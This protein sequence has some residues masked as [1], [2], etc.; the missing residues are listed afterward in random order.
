M[1]MP[2]FWQ[3][4][5]FQRASASLR[6]NA[7]LYL[8]QVSSVLF[9]LTSFG[10]LVLVQRCKALDWSRFDRRDGNLFYGLFGDLLLEGANLF[11]QLLNNLALSFQRFK[12]PRVSIGSLGLDS[13]DDFRL[14]VSNQLQLL[15][16]RLHLLVLWLK[17]LDNHRFFGS[18]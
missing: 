16:H 9:L 8:L 4:R 18:R 7:I 13:V 15:L 12:E 14:C 2:Y 10:S 3:S 6:T 5:S 1:T 11:H 17:R